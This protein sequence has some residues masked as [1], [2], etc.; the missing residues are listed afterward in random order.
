MSK[1]FWLS[2]LCFQAMSPKVIVLF[3]YRSR[4]LGLPFRVCVTT[5]CAGLGNDGNWSPKPQLS[6][7]LRLIAIRYPYLDASPSLK[8]DGI[9]HKLDSLR[10]SSWIGWSFSVLQI[11]KTTQ[12][13]WQESRQ[14]LSIVGFLPQKYLHPLSKLY[15]IR[16]PRP[17]RDVFGRYW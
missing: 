4:C 17:Q 6:Q 15:L 13:L 5:G 14:I 10:L 1:K 9:C 3:L 11:W 8:R 12:L 2:W 16:S 7:S